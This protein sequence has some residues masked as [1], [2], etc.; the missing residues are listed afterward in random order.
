[1][2]RNTI[3]AGVLFVLLT[4]GCSRGGNADRVVVETRI[5]DIVVQL[6]PGKAP[7]SVAAFLSF[8]DSGYYDNCSFYRIL[9]RDNQPMGAAAAELIQGGV[10]KTGKD[11]S[12]LRGIPHEP[13]SV[14]G[15]KH[16]NGTVSLARDEPGTATTEFFICLGDNPGFDFGGKSNPD[17]Q[18]YAAFGKVIEGMDIVNRIYNRP[19]NNQAFTPP[20]T[21]IKIYRQ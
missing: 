21:I 18:G 4:A 7:R 14:T 5:G 13:T 19:E 17:G 15:L 8:V 20:V 9:S 2:K 6:Y 10:Y 16:E 11:R 3:F 1:M 12:Y